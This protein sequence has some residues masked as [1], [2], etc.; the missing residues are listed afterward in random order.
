MDAAAP[1]L[2]HEVANSKNPK[3]PLCA[4]T[5]AVRSALPTEKGRWEMPLL[6]ALLYVEVAI[7]PRRT[8]DESHPGPES[9][10]GPESN[11]VFSA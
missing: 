3:F 6:D 5:T 8:T 2:C 10:L 9:N 7:E 1:C 4:N 11:P